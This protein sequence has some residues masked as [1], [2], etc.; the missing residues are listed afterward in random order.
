GLGQLGASEADVVRR[1]S[2]EGRR[3]HSRG[4]AQLG[5]ARAWP[6][7]IEEL[8]GL[9]L[10]GRPRILVTPDALELILRP[11]QAAGAEGGPGPGQLLGAVAARLQSA[12]VEGEP[13]GQF[14]ALIG[15]EVVLMV[16]G[17]LE[18]P[19]GLLIVAAAAALDGAVEGVVGPRRPGQRL[20]VHAR[21]EH[22]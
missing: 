21:G 10:V 16:L 9:L 6:D 1:A 15:G 17:I 5:S 8:A 22:Q 13:T 12:V 11:D 4:I 20:T 3:V 2:H 18:E 14:A 19:G 7:L